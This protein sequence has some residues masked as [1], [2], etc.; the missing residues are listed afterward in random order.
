MVASAGAGASHP[1]GTKF[2]PGSRAMTQPRRR[3]GKEDL[4]FLQS[5]SPRPRAQEPALVLPRE[6]PLQGPCEERRRP[7]NNE[8]W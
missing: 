8:C 6:A 3:M 1:S 5:H 4:G 2:T 7:D